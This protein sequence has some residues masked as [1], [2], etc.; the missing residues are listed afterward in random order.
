MIDHDEIFRLLVT[1]NG[2]VADEIFELNDFFDFGVHEK[3]LR[4]DE[5]LALL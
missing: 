4:L 2:L 3:S 1:T 5:F